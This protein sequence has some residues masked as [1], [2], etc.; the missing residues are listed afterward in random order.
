LLEQLESSL[1]IIDCI[2]DPL[3]PLPLLAV[4]SQVNWKFWKYCFSIHMLAP[5]DHHER[6]LKSW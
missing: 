2:F 5:F 1:G 4:H 3:I 6:F